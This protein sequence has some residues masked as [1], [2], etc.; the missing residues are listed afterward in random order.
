MP[1]RTVR[2]VDLEL[3]VDDLDRAQNAGIVGCAQ[4]EADERERVE[5][6]YRGRRPRRLIRGTVFDRYEAVTRRCGARPI[7]L[8]DAQVVTTHPVLLPARRADDIQPSLAG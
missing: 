7:P 3:R 6:D 5:A 8:G 2:R 4:S 1:R